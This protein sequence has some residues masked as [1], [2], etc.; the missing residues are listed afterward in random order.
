MKSIVLFFVFVCLATIALRSATPQS[1]ATPQTSWRAVAVTFDDLPASQNSARLAEINK[2][3]VEG[4][5]RHRIPAVGF[6][7]ESKL[8]VRGKTDARIALLRLWLDAGLELGNHTFS[9]IQINN[10]SLDEYKEDVIRGETVTRLLLGEKGK[11][12]RYF[13]HTQ[14]RTGPTPDY[15]RELNRFLAARGYTVAPVTIDNQEWVYAS[16]YA[17]ALARKDQANIERIVRD[18]FRHL[19]E[20]FAF[21]EQL[22]TEVLGY[23]VKQTLLL[24]ANELNADHFDA[25]AALMKRRGY[26]FL[27]LEEALNDPAYR[28]PTVSS[29]RGDSWLHRWGSAKGLKKRPEPREPEWLNRLLESYARR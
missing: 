17:A 16:A 9:H 14:L 22:S 10:A 21:F 13:R 18:Y 15:E 2:K 19:E 4:I 6:V 25:L 27:S 5:T 8:Y 23:E 29:G 24:H 3:L 7:N 28:L 12:L 26:R 1:R 20:C 11:K